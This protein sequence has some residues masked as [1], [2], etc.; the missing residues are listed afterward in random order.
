MAGGKNKTKTDTISYKTFL[1]LPFKCHIGFK[2]REETLKMYT[3]C[4]QS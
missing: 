4:M 3:S 2:P 1:C